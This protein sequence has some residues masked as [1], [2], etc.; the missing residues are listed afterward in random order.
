MPINIYYTADIPNMDIEKFMSL[1][2]RQ[3][4]AMFVAMEVRNIME[5]FHVKHLSDEQMKELN[6]LIRQGI[7]NGLELWD[8]FRYI[9]ET[10]KQKDNLAKY[11]IFTLA[12]IPDYWEAPEDNFY[13]KF[14]KKQS[15]KHA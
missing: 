15:E 5:E 9:E 2:K 4:E 1:S 14:N 3:Q 10:N 13:K 8:E 11:V 7:A 6:P 12:S